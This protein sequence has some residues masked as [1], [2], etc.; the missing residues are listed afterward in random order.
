[1]IHKDKDWLPVY[2]D[3]HSIGLAACRLL[4]DTRLGKMSLFLSYYLYKGIHYCGCCENMFFQCS[5]FSIRVFLSFFNCPY[6]QWLFPVVSYKF[7]ELKLNFIS[8]CVSIS[9]K[10]YNIKAYILK[11]VCTY[12]LFSIEFIW[13]ILGILDHFISGTSIKYHQPHWHCS[14][15]F[16]LNKTKRDLESYSA[17]LQHTN[18][19]SNAII[20]QLSDSTI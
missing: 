20:H 17:H 3:G 4:T 15:L 14:F 6:F 8:S 9:F 13:N 11:L 19:W 18:E 10:R 7:F 1:M 2:C 12:F 5:I 16:F